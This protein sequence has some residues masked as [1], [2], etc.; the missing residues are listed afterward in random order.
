MPFKKRIYGNGLNN[1]RRALPT[2][3]KLSLKIVMAAY[4]ELDD[5]D[6][7]KLFDLIMDDLTRS[8]KELIINCNRVPNMTKSEEEL[9]Q[10][11]LSLPRLKIND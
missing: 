2:A 1:D 9:Y 6:K 3:E 11:G 7:I 5:S 10:L 8:R 4:N